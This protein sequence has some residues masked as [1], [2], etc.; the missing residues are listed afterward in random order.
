M[1]D[2]YHI[3]F[4][5]ELLGQDWL[6]L[7]ATEILDT[8]YKWTDVQDVMEG[9]THLTT[10]QKC[11]LLDILQC[12]QKLFDGMLGIYP[13]KMVH[14]EIE[15]GAKPVHMQPYPVPRIQLSTFKRE[16]GSSL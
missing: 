9:Q 6:D 10:C 14:I 13:H 8:R 2:M 16:T 12:H 5:D 7:Y 11:D 3:Q 1:E 15:P 4:E